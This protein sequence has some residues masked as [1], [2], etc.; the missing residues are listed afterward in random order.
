MLSKKPTQTQEFATLFFNVT[1]MCFI[2][3]YRSAKHF[4]LLS[5]TSVRGVCVP[6]SCGTLTLPCKYIFFR[7]PKFTKNNFYTLSKNNIT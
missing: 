5:I 7:A 1:L 6:G 2:L 3:Y 4:N